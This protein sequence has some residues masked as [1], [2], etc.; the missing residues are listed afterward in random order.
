MTTGFYVL[1]TGVTKVRAGSPVETTAAKELDIV[2]IFSLLL[3]TEGDGINLSTL[4][5]SLGLCLNLTGVN[6]CF[7][8]NKM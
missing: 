2:S 3:K 1:I 8:S 7:P 5:A 4:K 6:H